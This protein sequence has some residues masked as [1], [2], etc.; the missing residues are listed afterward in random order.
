VGVSTSAS[1]SSTDRTTWEVAEGLLLSNADSMQLQALAAGQLQQHTPRNSGGAFH[2]QMQRAF[3][4]HWQA[5]GY[6]PDLI[7]A[8][9]MYIQQGYCS[10]AGHAAQ[11][12][13]DPEQDRRPDCE[14]HHTC[15]QE[16]AH[17]Q[18]KDHG[19]DRGRDRDTGQHVRHEPAPSSRGKAAATAAPAAAAVARA[20]P[21]AFAAAGK[22]L[23]KQRF[24][25]VGCVQASVLGSVTLVSP[26]MMCCGLLSSQ[27]SS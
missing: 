18:E 14:P 8:C 9:S 17:V 11:S 19:M 26:R 6:S 27:Q 5:L 4:Q 12:S 2:M 3:E 10:S 15:E 7:N 16:R 13:T 22:I 24:V 23:A 1:D 21:A 20:G 25:E